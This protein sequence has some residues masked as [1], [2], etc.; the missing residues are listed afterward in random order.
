MGYEQW[1]W[2]QIG[3]T[4][5]GVGLYHITLPIPTHQPLLGTLLIPNNDP[6]KAFVERT[7]LGDTLIDRL[8]NIYQYYPQVQ[9]LHFCLMP[10]HLHAIL[11]VRSPMLIGIK[12]VVR[13]FWQ[14]AKQL[15][16]AVSY[17]ASKNL[18]PSSFT[19]N[20]IRHKFQ[21]EKS[22]LLSCADSLR[23]QLSNDAYCA[24]SPIFTQ[25]P[26]V[27]PMSHNT[28]LPATIRY[29][30]MNPQRLATKR[31]RPGF[32]CVQNNV[33]INGRI[34]D[35]VG[36]TR[37]LNEPQRSP[38]HVRHTMT[39]QARLGNPQPLQDYIDSCFSAANQGSVMVS[40]FI[41]SHER[42]IL[43]VLLSEHR[44]VI[45]LAD[46]GFRDY[47][48]PSD[49]LFDAVDAGKLLILSPWKR[50]PSKHHISRADCIALNNIAEEICRV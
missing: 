21:E 15:G 50:D 24:L 22:A 27:Q 43:T 34:Y 44:P 26:H 17:L 19:S 47:Y 41:S 40:P 18:S 31:L 39:E 38:V 46:N 30:D 25:M 35:A 37:I 3:T 14:A 45:Y 42:D 2:Q 48:K 1:K 5:K 10:D 28:Q 36:N 20:S 4:W 29:I 7:P 13:G 12:G 33:E 9:V 11:Y 32:F 6:A 8:L 23:T 16:R 49:M